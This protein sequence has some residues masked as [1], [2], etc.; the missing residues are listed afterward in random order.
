MNGERIN[1][2]EQNKI[3]PTADA[4]LEES[5]ASRLAQANLHRLRR[6]WDE[7][8]RVCL[9]VLYAAPDSWRAH[10]L[11]GDIAAER[12]DPDEAI[13][14]YCMALDIRP[15][16]QATRDKLSVIVNSRRAEL[17]KT[18]TTQI[19]N[20]LSSAA[21][22]HLMRL[23]ST[24]AARRRGLAAAVGVI[25]LVGI[26][27][28]IVPL[29]TSQAQRQIIE[30]AFTPTSTTYTLDHPN[31]AG[32]QPSATISPQPQA[33]AL[34]TTLA[35][36][37]TAVIHSSPGSQRSPVPSSADADESKLAAA[38]QRDPSLSSFNITIDN[39]VID[40]SDQAAI[41]TVS[42]SNNETGTQQTI[43]AS[44]E[45]VA[46][47]ALSQTGAVPL[48]Q[49]TVRYMAL[50]S[51]MQTIVFQGLAAKKGDQSAGPITSQTLAPN[52]APPVFG[53]TWWLPSFGGV[54]ENQGRSQPLSPVN[55]LAGQP[56]T[57]PLNS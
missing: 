9:H 41:L 10:A 14:W 11:L 44:S 31:S 25:G 28:I 15:D 26:C 48:Q 30:P 4:I 24:P 27:L 33:P 56:S 47:S 45:A 49:C 22:F 17:N 35:A 1:G 5:C 12:G 50:L 54:Q 3:N 29:R 37:P 46:K 13:R 57:A 40:P 21:P 53:S 34:V 6:Q 52:P 7:A 51:G 18:I 16:A 36:A 32:T 43:L 55:S 2:D 20:Q 38:L 39:C 42:A 19:G 8:N 23:L